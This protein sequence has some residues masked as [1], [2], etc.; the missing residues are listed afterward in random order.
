M[1]ALQNMEFFPRTSKA[2]SQSPKYWVKEKDRYL[3]QLLI[4]DIQDKTNRE[5]VVYFTSSGSGQIDFR[6]ADDIS[7]VLADCKT[8][9]V[10]LIIQTPGGGGYGDKEK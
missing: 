2:P 3:R 5:L 7:E 9:E 1:T 4:K 10:D 6:D 8:K